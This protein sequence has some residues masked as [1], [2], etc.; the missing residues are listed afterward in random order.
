MNT[1][2]ATLSEKEEIAKGVFALKFTKPE[3]I[4]FKAGQFFQWVVPDG[5]KHVLRSYS[6]CSTPEDNYIEFCIKIL[7]DGK[8]SNLVLEMKEGDK[9]D[10]KGPQGRFIADE[11]EKP[12][13]MIA[14][15]T[16]LA[17][18]IGIIRDQLE[19]KKTDKK[20]YLLF[21]VR[22]EED[23]FWTKR[24]EEIEKNYKNFTLDITLS[25]PEKGWT[26]KSGRV[27]EHLKNHPVD[28]HYFLCGNM[29]MVKEV[30]S[31]L[32]EGGIDAKCVHFEI[33]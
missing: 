22:H 27:T 9:L 30:R 11:I 12:L 15:G 24:L 2:S 5:E 10:F 29:P 31:L 13:F 4:E 1:F 25:K 28:H 17:P 19:N 3:A 20:I 33:F 8:A 16:G 18:M 6:V 21:G 23:V 7:P 32:I 26:G 14:T